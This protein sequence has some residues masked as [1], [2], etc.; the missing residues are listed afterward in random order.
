VKNIKFPLVWFFGFVVLLLIAFVFK[1]LTFY[2]SLQIL[3]TFTLVLV[4]T[5]YTIST[6]KMAKEMELT[7]KIQNRPSIIAYFDN[8][9]SSLLELIVK[10]IGYG[11]AETVKFKIEP[12]MVDHEGR[13]IANLSLFKQ[14]ISNFPPN[15]EFHQIIGTST[16]FFNKESNRPL[17]YDL[18]ISYKD[19]DGTK[20]QDQLIHL[21]LSVYRNL[22]IHRESDIDKLSKE[23][24]NLANVIGAKG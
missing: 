24:K 3:L 5:I 9:Q 18:T 4:T 10:N 7:R 2:E 16:Q 21:D 23:I 14:G 1:F 20:I 17:E 8:P 6:N 19:V 12:P 22:P 11:T 13:D 15:R